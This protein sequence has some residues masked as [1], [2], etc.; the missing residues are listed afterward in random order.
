MQFSEEDLR[1]ALRRKDPGT[2]FT[3]QVI[4]KVNRESLGTDS[5]RRP[6]KLLSRPSFSSRKLALVSAFLTV[7]V[8]AGWAQYQRARQRRAGEIAEQRT[9][10][11]LRITTVK[12][13][14]VFERAQAAARD[15]SK[16][17]ESYEEN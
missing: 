5:R 13:N 8:M 9:I 4:A 14:H 1:S 7:L 3:R 2:A 17:G 12:L 15:Q 16:S 6:E 11:A 10:F